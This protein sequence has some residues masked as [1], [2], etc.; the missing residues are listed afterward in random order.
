VRRRRLGILLTA[1]VLVAAAIGGATA[2]TAASASP[3][4]R[5][6]TAV[7]DAV[8][9]TEYT[10]GDLVLAGKGDSAS[11]TVGNGGSLVLLG[12]Y[13]VRWWGTRAKAHL[14]LQRR[15]GS[16]RWTT[17]SAKV[18]ST[19]DGLTVRTPRYS[20]T[21][22]TRTVSYRL[23]STA[24]S[25][26][27]GRVRNT[28]RSRV[29]RIGYENQARY[30]GLAKTVYRYAAAY[31]PN[32]AVHVAG[33]SSAAGDYATGTLL[34]RVVADVR[35]YRAKDVRALAL[36]ECSHERQ[37]LNYGGTVQGH[38]TMTAAAKRYFSHWALPAGARYPYVS[39]DR[40]I[41][42]IEHAADCGAQALNRGGYLGYGGYCSATQLREGKRLLQGHRY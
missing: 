7:V 35:S 13:D 14:S 33:L 29:A 31:C 22:A 24:Y 42:P 30:T 4:V 18:A 26:A 32:T 19:T 20:T 8:S 9:V 16:G 25:S 41:T 5:A 2:A 10:L 6:S 17:T 27:S 28:S 40:S 11:S 39:P 38:R 3:V 12:D 15:I 36:H 37:W 34:I 1:T 23:V 21:A